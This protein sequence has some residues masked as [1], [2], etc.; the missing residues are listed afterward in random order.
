MTDGIRLVFNN[1]YEDYRKQYHPSPDQNSAA[2]AIM[3]CKSG[4]LGV[5]A[6]IC[7][8]CGHIEFHNNSCR[9]RNCPSC[10]SVPRE[11]WI[12]NRSSEIIDASYYHVVLPYR[13][14]LTISSMP[15]R[16]CFIRSSTKLYQKHYSNS[17]R[18]KSSSEP[19]QASFKSFTLGGKR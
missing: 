16:L 19:P 6:A 9:N 13:L 15:I 14:S 18:M 3:R 12:D 4:L 10:Q 5:N 7:T 17:R 8:Q 1:F 2:Y 11:I